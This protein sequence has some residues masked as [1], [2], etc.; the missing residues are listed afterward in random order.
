MSP[1]APPSCLLLGG[2]YR[3]NHRPPN[4]RNGCSELCTD[5]Q[6]HSP[7]VLGPG[8]SVSLLPLT[9]TPSHSILLWSLSCLSIFWWFATGWLLS[10]PQWAFLSVVSKSEAP[11]C[12]IFET[13]LAPV[14]LNQ[15]L[16]PTTIAICFHFWWQKPYRLRA[17]LSD[18]V[19]AGF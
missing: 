1:G 8:F 9:V 4:P 10:L 15:P 17:W 3:K 6:R 13:V 18:S 19:A 2:K 11:D 14:W 5:M 16:V 12:L 7:W